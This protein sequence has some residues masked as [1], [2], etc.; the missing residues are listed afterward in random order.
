MF[1]AL[2]QSALVKSNTCNAYLDMEG[3]ETMHLESNCE[4]MYQLC[5]NLSTLRAPAMHAR[6][7]TFLVAAR[8][9]AYERQHAKH[10]TLRV[11]SDKHISNRL[12]VRASRIMPSGKH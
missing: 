2:P 1:V 7:R 10:M 11:T 3:C 9:A 4:H 6:R 8:S 12:R 5:L